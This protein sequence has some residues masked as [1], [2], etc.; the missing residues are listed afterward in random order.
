MYGDKF[1]VKDILK[2]INSNKLGLRYSGINY[3][4]TK[5]ILGINLKV[6]LAQADF[7]EIY[8]CFEF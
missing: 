2:S 3:K 5:F 8:G 1:G 6:N 4:N 7:I